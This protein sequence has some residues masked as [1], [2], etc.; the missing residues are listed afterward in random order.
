MTTTRLERGTSIVEVREKPVRRR[1]VAAHKQRI[2]AEADVRGTQ[3][4]LRELLRREGLYATTVRW[5]DSRPSGAVVRYTVGWMWP[6]ARMPIW[7]SGWIAA[8]RVASG[9]RWECMAKEGCAAV[10]A[11][12]V[13][14]RI[15]DCPAIACTGHR[16]HGALLVSIGK[17][18]CC[19]EKA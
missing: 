19:G 2:L 6:Y 13:A 3:G 4:P 17:R 5:P 18:Q 12:R 1:L 15:D 9:L 16:M 14:S 8:Q 11:S 7:P 10:G